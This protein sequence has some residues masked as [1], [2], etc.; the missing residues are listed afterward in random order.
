MPG[1]FSLEE[2]RQSGTFEPIRARP[3]ESCFGSPFALRRRLALRP[4]EVPPVRPISQSTV[5]AVMVNK[6]ALQHLGSW[7]NGQF[8]SNIGRS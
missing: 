6:N 7:G 3:T 2:P 5:L 8:T 4:D 1:R